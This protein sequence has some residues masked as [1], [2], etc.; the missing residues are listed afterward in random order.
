MAVDKDLVLETVYKHFQAL[1]AELYALPDIVPNPEPEPEPEP[2]ESNLYPLANWL[3]TPVPKTNLRLENR[4]GSVRP[5][6]KDYCPPFYRVTGNESLVKVVNRYSGRIN[7]WPVPKDLVFD[8]GSDGGAVIISPTKV[9]EIWQGVWNST[10]TQITAG[11]NVE[12]DINGNGVTPNPNQRVSASGISVAGGTIILEDF[13]DDTGKIVL[14]KEITHALRMS[15]PGGLI[16]NQFISPAVG[17]ESSG[18]GGSN[19]IPM[20]AR[21]TFQNLNLS[22]FPNLL[23]PFVAKVLKAIDTYGVYVID[24]SGTPTVSG[25]YIGTFTLEDGLLEKVYNVTH[26]TFIYSTIQ[27]QVWDVL[28]RFPLYRAN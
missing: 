28:A 4:I 17:A 23:H 24:G 26:D 20:G 25:K 13:M 27:K 7:N 12:F 5:S 8:T 21:Y 3:Y 15:L 18:S 14:D 2:S 9:M 10:K 6:S 16:N 22:E 11:G 19:G 1:R